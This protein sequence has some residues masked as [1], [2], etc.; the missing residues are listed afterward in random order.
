MQQVLTFH[1]GVSLATAAGGNDA[2]ALQQYVMPVLMVIGI[3]VVGVFLTFSI[4]RK[5]AR[6]SAERESAREQIEAIKSRGSRDTGYQDVDAKMS[7]I[8]DTVQDLASR[9][10]DRAARLE[11][12]IE[13]ADERIATM[14]GPLSCSASAHSQPHVDES[15]FSNPKTGNVA[16]PDA[17]VDEQQPEHVDETP[18][19]QVREVELDPLTRSVYDRHDQGM[20]P[21]DIAS[22]LD[23]Q[24]G[25][26]ELIL[27]LRPT[28][29]HVR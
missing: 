4:R 7:E 16:F 18:P 23:E 15:E 19:V 11:E 25:K 8:L 6:R 27:A 1:T 5:V 29:Q 26:V 21:V 12:L 24:I 22:E 3:V 14:S 9:L 28:E 10:N 2:D 20:A 13:Q 17:Q